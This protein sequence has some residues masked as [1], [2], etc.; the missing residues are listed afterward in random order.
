MSDGGVRR[1]GDGVGI[2]IGATAL[3]GVRLAHDAAGRV[4]AAAEETVARPDDDAIVDALVRLAARLAVPPGVA[5][6]LAW[7]P[8]DGYLHAVDVTGRPDLVA[9]TRE[10][11]EA[12]LTAA[13]L[14]EAGARRWLVAVRWDPA[15]AAQLA[16]MGERAGLVVDACEP[17][18]LAVARLLPAAPAVVAARRRRRRVAHGEHRRGRAH[19][20]AGRLR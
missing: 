6:R 15:R 9:V 4:A 12:G 20:R 18:P 2:E 8:P 3:R 7:F 16:A 10:L 14:V 13:T 1:R 11:G 5:V 17:A 19:G